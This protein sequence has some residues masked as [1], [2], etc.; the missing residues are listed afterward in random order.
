MGLVCNK[1]DGLPGQRSS[2]CAIRPAGFCR[3][4]PE[5]AK[6]PNGQIFFL[7]EYYYLLGS[8]HEQV[9]APSLVLHF[10]VGQMRE[11]CCPSQSGNSK[12]CALLPLE[13]CCFLLALLRCQ[14]G[15]FSFWLSLSKSLATW[16]S[17]LSHV[18]TE[19]LGSDHR[20]SCCVCCSPTVLGRVEWGEQL[21]LV[22]F[23]YWGSG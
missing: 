17:Q 22:C 3:R 14:G 2:P 16:G 7:R 4:L 8:L 6:K 10:L 11:L 12:F 21:L 23:A 15:R 9:S 5:L 18:Y 20:F 13:F 1:G 19:G